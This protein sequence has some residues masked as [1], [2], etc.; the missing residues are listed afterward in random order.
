[1]S[2]PIYW[3]KKNIWTDSDIWKK[4]TEIFYK[5]TFDIF[6]ASRLTN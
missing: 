4:N 1:M 3:N 6:N 2:W 5:K